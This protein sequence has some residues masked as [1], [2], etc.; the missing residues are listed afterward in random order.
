[1]KIGIHF[2]CQNDGIADSLRA[3]LPD[4]DIVNFHSDADLPERAQAE[5]AAILNACDHIIINH[6][7]ARHGLLSMAALQRSA[8]R[9]HVLPVFGFAGYQPD[10]VYVHA[11]GQVLSSA[12]GS[13]HSRI[14]LAGYLA[15]LDARDTAA[16]YNS[17]VF[18]RLGYFATFEEQVALMSAHW[19]RDGIEAE[20]LLRR[21]AA[22]GCFAYSINHP[23]IVVLLDLARI[24]CER[25]GIAPAN[26]DIDPASL[27]DKLAS[28]SMHPVYPEIAAALG[29]AP[30]GCFTGGSQNDT[31]AALSPLQFVS[32]SFARYAGVETAD[33]L[34]TPGIAEAMSALAFTLRVRPPRRMDSSMVLMTHHA[35]LLRQ[36]P[37]RG[38][39]SHAPLATADWEAAY[40][41]LD[42]ARL[43]ARQSGPGVQDAQIH[44]AA[45]NSRVL[46][47]RQGAFLSAD[48]AD[49]RAGFSRS[50]AGG[51]EHFLPLGETD[52]ALLQR[53]GAADWLV[54][55]TQ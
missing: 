6:A 14:A 23:K 32:D 26:P 54:E 21:W 5:R 47:S 15:G 8:R 38:E 34:A 1:M 49:G 35:T 12:T 17:L 51:W 22:R 40:L 53:L 50:T 55:E 28:G 10:M 13:Y 16:L 2:N 37:L 25:M 31:P 30:E 45:D 20:P 43:P 46:V 29:I 48:A 3:L 11:N 52:L 9:C 42:C 18:T 39:I 44:Y 41:R 27:P 33:L 19:A 7:D 36:G 24:A 4:A